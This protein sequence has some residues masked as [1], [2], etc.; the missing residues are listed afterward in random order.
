MKEPSYEMDHIPEHASITNTN[1][2]FAPRL[3]TRDRLTS[4]CPDATLTSPI[5][6]NLIRLP[7]Q[8]FGHPLTFPLLLLSGS[9]DGTQ[10]AKA[11]V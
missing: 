9:E 10:Q 3:P 6:L 1:I 4:A 11:A 5:S 8:S 7:V 2:L